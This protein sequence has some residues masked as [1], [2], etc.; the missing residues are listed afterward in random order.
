MSNCKLT[1]QPTKFKG[2]T[3]F[4]AGDCIQPTA[5]YVSEKHDNTTW[6]VILW[7]HGFHVKDFKTNIF[8][9]DTIRWQHRAAGERRRG[10]QG[11]GAHRPV[12]RVQ[13]SGG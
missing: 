2:K 4:T 8:G 6:N 7:F 9:D 13:D 3:R 11:R 10:R 5:V 12:A 1:E